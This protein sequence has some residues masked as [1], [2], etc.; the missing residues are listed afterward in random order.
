MPHVPASLPA[1][2]DPCLDC[3]ACCATYRVSF[4][5]AEP[6]SRGLPDHLLEPLTPAYA[7]MAGTNR[8]DP[9]CVALDGQVG[10]AVRCTVY[11]DRPS[12]CRELQPGEDKCLRA[13]QRHALP[14]LADAGAIWLP[15]V[16]AELPLAAGGAVAQQAADPPALVR[17]PAP[18]VPF[19]PPL[20]VP[21][22][23]P[24]PAPSAAL[25]PATDLAVPPVPPPLH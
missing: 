3:G 9:R 10:V 21:T 19:A 1:A 14:P 6:D 5:W 13:R 20:D 17:E 4:H 22:P 16:A 2:Q 18:A 15:G 24:L 12:G 23:Q 25:A 8:A 11:A 7:C